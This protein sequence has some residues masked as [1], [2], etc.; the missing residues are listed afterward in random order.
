MM[1]IPIWYGVKFHM[2]KTTIETCVDWQMSINTNMKYYTFVWYN[3]MTIYILLQHYY[4][5]LW[6]H[7]FGLNTCSVT[8]CSTFRTKSCVQL[9]AQSTG[10][11]CDPASV[12]HWHFYHDIYP[13]VVPDCPGLQTTAPELPLW[14]V[15]TP[16]PPVSSQRRGDWGWQ[17]SLPLNMLSGGHYNLSLRNSPAFAN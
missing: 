10:C 2:L 17:W 1:N 12:V 6:C 7:V 16:Q 15:S 8:H 14:D 13:V 4:E 5:K 11:L 3:F 9:S